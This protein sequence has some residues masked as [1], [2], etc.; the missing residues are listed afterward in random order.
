MPALG[1]D[2]HHKLHVLHRFLGRACVSVILSHACNTIHGRVMVDRCGK[3]SLLGNCKFNR[4]A[5]AHDKMQLA[6]DVSVTGEENLP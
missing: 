2:M 1:L 4:L 5:R 6:A 3:M